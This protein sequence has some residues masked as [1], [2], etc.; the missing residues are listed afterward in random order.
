MEKAEDL[1]FVRMVDVD[2]GGTPMPVGGSGQLRL[3]PGEK[4]VLHDVQ[5]WRGID[6]AKINTRTKEPFDF[7]LHVVTPGLWDVPAEAGP[8]ISVDGKELLKVLRK[9][10]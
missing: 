2:D 7:S 1:I 6:P 8:Y 3:K 5:W 4:I 9:K 10:P